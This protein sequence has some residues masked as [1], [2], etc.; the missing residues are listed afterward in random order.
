M[1]NI[2]FNYIFSLTFQCSLSMLNRYLL[3][4]LLILLSMLYLEEF[5]MRMNTHQDQKIRH[6]G[7][8]TFMQKDSKFYVQ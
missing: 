1:I 2:I 3:M 4:F 7:A 8:I 6:E 5:I